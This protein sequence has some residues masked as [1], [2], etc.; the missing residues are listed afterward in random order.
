MFGGRNR[1]AVRRAP[2]RCALL[3]GLLLLPFLRLQAAPPERISQA[4]MDQIADLLNEKASWTHAQQK[5]ESQLIHA[6]KKNRGAPFAPKATQ[7]ETD[8]KIHPDG[9][10][11][12]D[13][14]ANVTPA[15]L[16]LIG[17]N[18]QVLSSF[19]QFRAIRALIPVQE[20]ETIAAE[21]DVSFIRRA[22]E[23]QTHAGSQD[24]EGNL[25]HLA[26]VAR[27]TF[28]VTGAGVKVGVLSDSVDY[29]T[30]SQATG[31]LGAVT[32]LPGQSGING[33]NAGEGT[34]MLEIVHDLAPGAS[35]YF[36]TAFISEASFA[37][38]ILN[39]RS[40]GCDIIIDDV[41]Y[42]DESPFQDS[43]VARAVNTITAGGGLFFS[44]AG[45]SGNLSSGTSGTWEGDFVDGGS[46]VS[47]VAEP[48]RV[49]N[50]GPATF[51][52]VTP[53]GSSLR[54]DLFWADPL[55]ASANDY[56]F[57][58]LNAA[59]TSVVGSSLTRQNGS[60]DPYESFSTLSVG[61]RIVIVKFSGANRFLH[62]SSGRGQLSVATSGAI[63]GHAATTN[64]FGV[65]AVN[66][67]TSYP[68]GF[69]GGPT[70]PVEVY[71][72]DGPRHV[73]FNAD[74]TPMTPGNFTSTGGTIRQKPDIAATDDVTTSVPGFIPFAGTSAA[75]PHAGAIAA[76][77]KS[78]NSALTPGQIRAV[79]TG[80]TL[81]IMAPGV[82][83]DSGFGLVMVPAALQAAPTGALLVTPGTGFIAS[84]LAG[85][86]FSANNTIFS[87]TNTGASSLNWSVANDALWLTVTPTSGTLVPGGPAA[88]VTASLNSMSSNLWPGLY[89]AHLS[90][91]NLNTGI[92][93]NRTVRLLVSA[94]AA[95]SAYASNLLALNPI[96]YWRLNE[97]NA[98]APAEIVTNLGT[99]GSTANGSVFDAVVQ[100][101]P[102]IVNSSFRYQNPD[103]LVTYFGSHVDIPFQT[104][105]NPAGAFTVELWA[106]PAQI[107]TDVFSPA[108]S[109]DASLNS[110]N[111]RDG[112]LFY[113]AT[114]TWQFRVGGSSGYKATLTGGSAQSN[115]WHHLAG[116]YDGV[117]VSLYVDGT[118]VAGPTAA[119][120]FVA[121]GSQPF[122]V[123][124][125]TI[126]NR[127]FD[128]WVDEVAFYT[129]A[130]SA[131]V[132][133]AHFA[134]ATT[135]N[136][137][138]AAQIL[139][140]T[141][142]G[143]WRF[144]NTSTPAASAINS[145][146]I[147]P[148]AN[149]TYEPGTLPGVAGVPRSAFGS[150]NTACQFNGGEID[151][152][153]QF[154]SL[155]GPIT[156]SAWIKMNL[157]AG[158]ESIVDKG[159]GSY[160]LTVD[161]SGHPHFDDGNQTAGSIAGSG[162]VADGQWHQ[163]AAIYDGV[164]SEF[165]YVDGQLAASTVN[166]TNEI[167][168]NTGDLAIG[169]DPASF[170][171][172]LLGVIDEVALFTNALSAGTIQQ[173]YFAATNAVVTPPFGLTSIRGGQAIAI[174]WPTVPGRTYQV[175]YSTN[176]AGTNWN[177]VSNVTAIWPTATVSDPIGPD[178]QRFYRVV[179]LP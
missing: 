178:P 75:A 25:T 79:L 47:P 16:A 2:P 90:F 162:S 173:L 33:S 81:D 57:F 38:N 9:R 44:A 127:T 86:P 52:T 125:T 77:L 175:Q 10:V 43:V 32:V 170:T 105:L 142:R 68:G 136:S 55:G 8:V 26:T 34:A 5:M 84:G 7:L 123:G 70:N 98:P 53:G 137:G 71:S 174:T 60:Q 176:L 122:R 11:L 42:F 118:K 126:P 92:A 119:S 89:S 51:D 80:S 67:L 58:I 145:G 151:V 95:P 128:G 13:I 39:L 23:A 83:R 63:F 59:G 96:A 27:N 18:G 4:A 135:N 106:K 169:S 1:A 153:P 139:T 134:A 69:V 166:A 41:G 97:T 138:Y 12:V 112:W 94:P 110:G 177:V 157:P 46:T 17:R 132:I 144:E 76:L 172:N 147:A 50:F 93:Q 129:N 120:G 107:S 104:A 72:S 131:A 35:L 65:A 3:I 163:L 149:G 24:S 82:D 21:P 114:N 154:V 150:G 124:A 155:N 29:M 49:H 20:I 99:L 116:V 73:F 148:N 121:N 156:I 115:V 113:Q 102:G 36:A 40:N 6:A 30:N 87:L 31:D 28:G 161:T 103:M 100:G 62:L 37:Q 14:D 130:L 141:P 179:L 78:Y 45:N 56:D 64:A 101:E 152:A 168:G 111:S 140:A 165:L 74:G 88:A 117:N 146:S 91:T 133:A 158:T 109:I 164:H 22:V 160:R 167:T 108:S 66:S 48:G 15:L 54:V 143:Y 19:P 159:S 171:Q 61:Q 85:G